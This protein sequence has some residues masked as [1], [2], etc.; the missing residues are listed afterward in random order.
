MMSGC[1]LQIGPIGWDLQPAESGVIRYS[2]PPYDGFVRVGGAGTAAVVL[3]LVV[4][5]GGVD[6]PGGVP[7]YRAGN[8][9]AIWDEGEAFLLAVGL[10]RRSC[11]LVCRVS[12]SLMEGELWVNGDPQES[13]LRYPLDQVL[14][15]G[16]LAQ[17]GGFLMHAAAVVLDGVAW[18]LTGRSGAG[19]S[20][21]SGLC[22]EAGWEVLNDDRVILYEERGE[23]RVSGTPWHGSGCFWQNRQV[24]LGGVFVLQQDRGDVVALLGRRESR[25][26]LLDTV[27]VPWFEPE[28]SQGA[29]DAV[30]T[31]TEAVPVSRFR[32]TNSA[33][34]VN[35][36]GSYCKGLTG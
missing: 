13:P 27:S 23:W 17:C 21:L 11:R 4:R 33:A 8:N 18:V 25:L 10:G 30:A 32:F 15:W 1:L 14:A 19:K 31:A 22:R 6:V 36:L 12:R 7:L 3:P 34:A 35:T 24:P 29:L 20:T 16:M 26:A 2:T 28:W 9:W 5:T